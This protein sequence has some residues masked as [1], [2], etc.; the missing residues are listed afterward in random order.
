[1]G[2]TRACAKLSVVDAA[3]QT[4]A[5]V[6][7][8]D[9]DCVAITVFQ[10]DPYGIRFSNPDVG[11]QGSGPEDCRLVLESA[12]ERV[13]DIAT[14]WA[15]ALTRVSADQGRSAVRIDSGGEGIELAVPAELLLSERQCQL[16]QRIEVILSLLGGG[17]TP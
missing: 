14:G 7:Q 6:R 17:V 2:L 13:Q 8:Q 12:D 15:V 3:T 4:L 16:Q 11:D 10:L 1:V 9:H 5:S